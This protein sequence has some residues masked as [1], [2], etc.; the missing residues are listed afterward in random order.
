MKILVT[1]Y[2]GFIGS[3]LT[4]RLK[5]L[6][7]HVAGYEWGEKFPG[8]DYEVIM[9]LGA[10]S[11]TNETDVNKLISQNYEFSVWLLE[12]CNRYGIN[13]QYASS[14]GVYGNSKTFSEFDQV[15]PMS[16]YAWT[17][18]LFEKY[19]H[20]K[21]YSIVTQG[22]RYFNVYGPGEQHKK[23]PS[24]YEA[25]SRQSEIKLFKG[26]ENIKRDFVTVEKVVETHIEFL[27]VPESGIWNI[28]SG[29]TTSFLEVAQTFGKP[30][31][32][33]DIPE[34]IKS[35]YQ[36]YTCADITKLRDTINRYSLNIPEF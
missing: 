3:N 15:I 8:Y 36:Y 25:F 19:V 18:Y 10:I 17:K 1:G 30:I 7:H 24:P 6:G 22:F 33:V 11:S 2:K 13:L 4:R 31:T 14:A 26:S 5:E 16:P 29:R 27:K 9:H 35:T 20:S 32:Y 28:G 12:T 34:D 21:N 23:Q